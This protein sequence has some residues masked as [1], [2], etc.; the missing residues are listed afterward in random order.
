MILLKSR[1]FCK[2]FCCGSCA[3][4]RTLTLY[5]QYEGREHCLTF[6][7]CDGISRADIDKIE[8]ELDHDCWRD[9]SEFPEWFQQ[10]MFIADS[11]SDI[12]E[13]ERFVCEDNLCDKFLPTVIEDV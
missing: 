9:G 11:D 2:S 13:S 3:H 8:R 6:C 4:S 1:T 7:F 10:L 12:T 5:D